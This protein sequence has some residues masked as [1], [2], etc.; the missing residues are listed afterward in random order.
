MVY[1]TSWAC[2]SGTAIAASVIEMV[3]G[4]GLLPYERVCSLLTRG[5]HLCGMA[6][7]GSVGGGGWVEGVVHVPADVTL[8]RVHTTNKGGD[9]VVRREL[10]GCIF[11]I[12]VDGM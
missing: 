6:K 10:A 4:S 5:H 2:D 8:D 9:I 3:L 11:A 1:G 12:W 7:C